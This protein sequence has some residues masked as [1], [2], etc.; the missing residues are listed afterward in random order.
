MVGTHRPATQ[1]PHLAG[2]PIDDDVQAT[3]VKQLEVH[4]LAE[5]YIQKL[6][7]METDESDG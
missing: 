3:F 1:I 2:Q 7:D 5:D 6:E 4:D